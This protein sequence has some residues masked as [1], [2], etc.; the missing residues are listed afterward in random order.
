M[1]LDLPVLLK[2]CRSLSLYFLCSENH[3]HVGTGEE[4]ESSGCQ[5]LAISHAQN[6]DTSHL[7]N[8]Y[9]S[10]MDWRMRLQTNSRD[11]LPL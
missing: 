2:T 8:Q 9:V 10:K 6:A 1:P 11:C 4:K 5:D 7:M 3:Q